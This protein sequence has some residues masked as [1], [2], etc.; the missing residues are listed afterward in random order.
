MTEPLLPGPIWLVGCGNM[1]GAMLAGWIARDADPRQ[2]TVIRPSGGSGPEGV[3]V[4]TALPEDEVPALAMLGFKPQQLDAV[5][6]SL[7]PALEPE[8]I[9]V[10]I[11]AGVELASLR[12]RFAAPRTIVRAMPN[13]PVRLNRGV[14]ALFAPDA[15]DLSRAT[16]ERLM[17]ALGHVEWFAEEPLFQLAGILGGA[18]P[19]FLFRFIDALAAAASGLGMDEAQAARI[20]AF[21]VEG[22]AALA[23]ASDETPAALARRVASPKGT[24]EA[25]LAV[26]DREQGLAAL[27]RDTLEAAL[28]RSREMAEA[29]RARPD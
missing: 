25:G 1:A 8:T 3:R 23:T 16:V 13:L 22:A 15:D 19:A 11:L 27:V 14:V 20:A 12:A 4:L 2:V 28:R 26:L 9:L 21:M 5:A 7:S 24:T 18:G 29:A 10:S 17:A 6:P